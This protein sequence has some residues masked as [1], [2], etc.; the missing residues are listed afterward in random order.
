MATISA[1][2]VKYRWLVIVTFVAM[3][4][5]MGSQLSKLTIDAE[6]ANMIPK[7][8]GFRAATDQIEDIFGGTDLLIL[9]FETKDVLNEKTLNRIKSIAK[10]VNR[11]NGVDK[12]MS[13]FDLK[14]IKGEDGVMI[15]DPAVKDIPK[16][17]EQR[18]ILRQEIMA[19]DLVY[20]TIVSQD[21]RFTA[22]IMTM[23]DD[24]VDREVLRAV[25]QIL[26]DFPGDEK[27]TFGGIP[28]IREN[29]ARDIRQDMGRLMPL[30]LLIMLIFLFVAFR[31]VRGVLLP[32]VIVVMSI[33]IAMGLAPTLG[34]K[35]YIPTILVPIIMI[36]V[37]NDYGIHL[38]AKFQE[39]NIEGH[40]FS[41]TEMAQR[42]FKSLA[43]PVVLTGLTTI[44]GMLCLLTHVMIPAK[45]LGILA[46]VG[47][48]YALVASLLFIPAVTTL[49]P[50]PKP[51]FYHERHMK[52]LLDRLLFRL[53]DFVTAK[54]KRI[55]AG[56]AVCAVVVGLGAFLIQVDAN[57]ESYYDKNHPLVQSSELIND[58]FG[59]AQN[60][61]LVFSGDIKNPDMMKKI[62]KY[63]K[64]LKS[65]PQ[66]GTTTSMA[67]VVRQMSRALND[68]GEVWYD[69]IPDD[70]NAIAQYF[71][72]YSMSGD[73][74]DFDKLVD[75]TYENAHLMARIKSLSTPELKELEKTL[76]SMQAVDKDIT[77]VGGFAMIFSQLARL[78]IT[79]QIQSLFLAILLVTLLLMALFRSFWAGIVSAMP[80]VL[81]MIILFGLM[82]YFGITLNVATTMLSSIMIGVGIDY[83]IHFLWRYKEERQ[84]GRDPVDAVKHTIITTGRGI[85]FNAL[86]VIFGFTA[87]LISNFAPVR[88]FGFLVFVSIFACLVGAMVLIPAILMLF[89]PRFLEPKHNSQ[90]SEQAIS[91]GYQYPKIPA[92]DK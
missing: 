89:K 91:C 34:W 90:R 49:L 19:N 68:S 44:V 83:T 47:I 79:G 65:Y 46:A 17:R 69:K 20:E 41:R 80:L 4:I 10:E 52:H 60:V 5:I 48:A 12:V 43:K 45:Q 23:G 15:V 9:L 18:E 70:R 6:F 27:V 13:L 63:E 54:P 73:P 62:E 53:A 25:E 61:S 59:G 39:D 37:A 57:P 58:H 74:D 56:S 42:M 30:G 81:A 24:A 66:V 55:L 40:A 76:L 35:V 92:F 88:F 2:I 51:V 71:E 16:T 33:I 36:A 72:L 8:M 1:F 77:L 75:F 22:I 82:G 21:F 31:Q 38:V 11:I 78:M 29:I 32:F 87:L 7:N 85:T 26:A 84:T 14:N 86:S 67:Q 3:T 64:L 28:Y 50:M